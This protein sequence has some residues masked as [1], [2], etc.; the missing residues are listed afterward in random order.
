MA[1]CASGQ[2]NP[3]E[4]F[5]QGQTPDARIQSEN[6]GG[7]ASVVT[8]CECVGYRGVH[9][10]F[11]MGSERQTALSLERTVWKSANSKWLT[12]LCLIRTA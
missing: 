12:V 2:A 4:A 10:R 5:C 6:I 9:N 7:Q 8:V 3:L 1:C 11:V